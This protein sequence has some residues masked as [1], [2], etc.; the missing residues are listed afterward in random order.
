MSYTIFKKAA[1]V[2]ACG[3]TVL[4]AAA[5]DIN[6]TPYLVKT[7]PRDQVKLLKSLTSGGNIHVAGQTTGDA[8]VEVYVR[9]NDGGRYLSHDE[10]QQRMD[11]LVELTV[12]VDAGTL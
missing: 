4:A 2:M 6:E 3:M 10:A 12:G 1:L 5:Q 8:K 7:F 9:S 11:E